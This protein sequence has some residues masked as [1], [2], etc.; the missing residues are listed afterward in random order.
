MR[1]R[2]FGPMLVIS[3]NKGGAYIICDLDGTLA[4]AP[5]AAF[6]V[7]PYFARRE[8]DIPDIEEHID[9]SVARLREL[10]QTTFADPDDPEATDVTIEATDPE[11]REDDPID[12]R[13]SDDDADNADADA[14]ADD[15]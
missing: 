8:L 14:D 12:E 9:V 15:E 4:H 2:Y 5:V 11:E 10:E 1:P 7:V 6:R 3:R 13:N